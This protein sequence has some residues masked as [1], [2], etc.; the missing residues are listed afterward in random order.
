MFKIVRLNKLCL[1]RLAEMRVTVTKENYS[2]FPCFFFSFLSA[3]LL[4]SL[5]LACYSG[6]PGQ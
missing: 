6:I 2:F 3:I 4:I 1:V 5:S